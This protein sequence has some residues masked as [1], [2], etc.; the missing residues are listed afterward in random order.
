MRYEKIN[1]WN[2]QTRVPSIVDGKMNAAVIT[3]RINQ[4]SLNLLD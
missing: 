1:N 4:Q 3:I 2:E